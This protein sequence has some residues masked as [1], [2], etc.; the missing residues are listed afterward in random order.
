MS[1]KV[2]SKLMRQ[3]QDN[4]AE[5]RKLVLQSNMLDRL[6]DKLENYEQEKQINEVKFDIPSKPT[7]HVTFIQE[8]ESQSD[9]DSDSDSD[10]E[11]EFD[12]ESDESI[13]SS[14]VKYEEIEFDDEDDDEDDD[15]DYDSINSLK[16][17]ITVVNEDIEPTPILQNVSVQ[18]NKN[19]GRSQEISSVNISK[20][21][22]KREGD[23]NKLLSSYIPIIPRKSSIHF[24]TH[25]S[26]IKEEELD[27]ELDQQLEIDSSDESIVDFGQDNYYN[28]MPELCQSNSL[29]DD[30]ED[31]INFQTSDVNNCCINL[32]SGIVLTCNLV[33]EIFI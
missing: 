32:Q 28:S 9:S 7:T 29:T 15:Y 3:S 1:S 17:I 11:S 16:S 2:R 31:E 19:R 27:Q 12:S 6:L 23:N 20:I 26:S 4:K 18:E 14:N 25:L 22:A 33:Q 24:E 21:D 8:K 13:F 10:S 30:E 5:L